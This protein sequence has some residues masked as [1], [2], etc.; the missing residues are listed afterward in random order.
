MEV[1]WTKRRE[2]GLECSSP[3]YQTADTCYLKLLGQKVRYF[4]VKCLL[5]LEGGTAALFCVKF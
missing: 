2:G 1:E 5:C 4:Y 3:N